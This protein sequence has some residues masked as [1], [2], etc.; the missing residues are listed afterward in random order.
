LPRKTPF[1]LQ[2]WGFCFYVGQDIGQ[3]GLIECF[4]AAVAVLF[5]RVD[6]TFV[7]SEGISC[8]TPLFDI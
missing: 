2:K 5:R 7:L 6:F 3:S 1:L 4:K 8:Q